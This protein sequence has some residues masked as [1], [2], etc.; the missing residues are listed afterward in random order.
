[1]ADATDEK[2]KPESPEKAN[3]RAAEKARPKKHRRRGGAY[4]FNVQQYHRHDYGL[5]GKCHL[6]VERRCDGI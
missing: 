1:M 2:Q 5:P 4:P 3:E 6:V